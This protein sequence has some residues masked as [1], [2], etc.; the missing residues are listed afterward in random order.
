MVFRFLIGL[1]IIVWMRM[2]VYRKRIGRF[3]GWEYAIKKFESHVFSIFIV[4][5]GVVAWGVGEFKTDTSLWYETNMDVDCLNR[6]RKSY[7]LR[8]SN[9]TI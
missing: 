8:A 2:N 3:S 7:L 1:F 5:K 9:R 6:R 4:L